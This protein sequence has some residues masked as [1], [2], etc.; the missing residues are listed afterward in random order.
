MSSLAEQAVIDAE[1]LREAAMR[2]AESVIYERY[3]SEIKGAIK[4][5]LEQGPMGGMPMDP[6]MM[7]GMAPPMDPAV[8]E[9]DLAATEGEKLCPC[10]DEGETVPVSIDLDDL[11]AV[12]DMLKAEEEMAVPQAPMAPPQMD[13]AM[14]TAPPMDPAMMGGMPMEE[15]PP[16]EEMMMEGQLVDVEELLSEIEVKDFVPQLD[17]EIEL[18]DYPG[19]AAKAGLGYAGLRAADRFRQ[20]EYMDALTSAPGDFIKGFGGGLLGT[21]AADYFLDNKRAQGYLDSASEKLFGPSESGEERAERAAEM[22]GDLP[23]R[24]YDA[25][26]TPEPL[27]EV[28]PIDTSSEKL[29]R[30][31]DYFD[32][33]GTYKGSRFGF[34]PGTQKYR[35]E[36]SLATMRAATD[37]IDAGDMSAFADLKRAES[38]YNAA[39]AGGPT[40]VDRQLGSNMARATGIEDRIL[41][42]KARRAGRGDARMTRMGS[43]FVDPA[44]F[45]QTP[46]AGSGRIYQEGLDNM[47]D[48]NEEDLANLVEELVVDMGTTKSG[49]MGTPESVVDHAT[50]VEIAKMAAEGEESDEE[51]DDSSKELSE[52]YSR[53]REHN[54]QLS[55]IAEQLKEKLEDVNL[56][57]AKL[58]Y[59][60]R[61]LSDRSLNGRQK[62]KIVE[63]VNDAGSVEQAK[64]I[65]ETLQ[66]AVTSGREVRGKKTLSEAISRPSTILPRRKSKTADREMVFRDRMKILAG[67]N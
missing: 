27:P 61:A 49:W 54:K 12:S 16:E 18:S 55:L 65:Y 67:I 36:Q 20:G 42:R 22:I 19:M 44:T 53:L 64:L 2:N 56:Q 37:R 15:L 35:Q 51:T 38:A 48:I 1:N 43:R 25:P 17:R 47:I 13:P 31:E 50:D 9:I 23:D 32:P 52:N 41:G 29:F 11:I 26:S 39:T 6:G 24:S 57:N 60:N 28:E 30:T 7:G 14:M 46:S 4:T 33:E 8:Q 66:S 40:R 59:T 3:S 21:A 10:P 58:F 62:N 63:A 34:A 45:V 5:I